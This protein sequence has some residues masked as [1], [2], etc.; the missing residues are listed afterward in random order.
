MNKFITDVDHNMQNLKFILGPELYKKY[1]DIIPLLSLCRYRVRTYKSYGT[2]D[3]M[4]STEETSTALNIYRNL[5]YPFVC[6]RNKFSKIPDGKKIMLSATILKNERYKSLLKDLS[7]CEIIRT[8]AKSDIMFY[9]NK[10]SLSEYFKSLFGKN[11]K[12]LSCDTVTGDELKIVISDWLKFTRNLDN[13]NID[14]DTLR[15]IM[16]FKLGTVRTIYNNRLNELISEI[17]NSCIEL[18]ITINQYNIRDFLLINACRKLGIKTKQ[19]EH[20]ASRFMHNIADSEDIYRF[21]YVDDICRWSNSEVDFHKNIYKYECFNGNARP[22]IYSVGN[23]EISYKDALKAKKDYPVQSRITFM[24]SGILNQTDSSSVKK[25]LDL[26]NQIFDGLKKLSDK[27]GV[28]ILVRYPPGLD[29]DFRK[30]EESLLKELGFEISLSDRASL[31]S[32]ICGSKAVIGTISSVLGLSAL[33]GKY[34]Y[35]IADKGEEYYIT[36]KNIFTVS[37]EEIEYIDTE[38]LDMELNPQDFMDY[39]KLIK[40]I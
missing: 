24:I 30:K 17:K 19:L 23:P 5:I 18:Y 3:M 32:D 20:H 27:N 11:K 33:M 36:D 21:C 12:I 31:L 2:F 16:D 13:S 6:F 14:C 26:R 1:N 15:E 25:Q 29:M 34:V 39:D 35:Q 22:F 40:T 10:Q 4:F 28:K 8:N 37:P 7:G 38:K 9:S